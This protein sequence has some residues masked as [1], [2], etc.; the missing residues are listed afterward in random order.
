MHKKL[1]LAILAN[2]FDPIFGENAGGVVHALQVFA[3][4]EGVEI[5]FYGPSIARDA[6]LQSVPD[7][8]FV[9]SPSLS[10]RSEKFNQLSRAVLSL[11][12]RAELRSYD[13]L[14]ATSHFIADVLPLVLSRPSRSI[15]MLWHVIPPPGRRPGSVIANTIA[16]L[17]E[18]FSI[19]LIRRFIRTIIVGSAE[20]V[21]SLRLQGARRRIYI[22]TN[23]VDHLDALEVSAQ[24]TARDIG[25]LYIGRLHPSKGIG[26]LL[27]AWSLLS[28]SAR[29]QGLYL[30]GASATDYLTE[31]VERAQ[32]L[33]I[34]DC[35][36]FCGRVEEQEKWRLL[37]RARTFVFASTEEGWGIAIAEAMAA[38]VPCVTYDL[39][40]FQELF[41]TGRL[42]VAPG[43][44]D[45][46][47][48]A[49]EL[50]LDDNGLRQRLSDE[51]RS[52]GETF[53]WDRAA[54]IEFD[55]IA[56]TAAGD[57]A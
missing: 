6:F 40:V 18:R 28:D 12:I 3:R 46:L 24:P 30:A 57:H 22:T 55:A 50:V 7:S 8:H 54:R 26:D 19:F 53:S 20:L 10:T 56:I 52:L 27:E 45:A 1:R 37:A 41:A 48:R 13:A 39:P 16:Y 21:R 23:G 29:R 51:A 11:R 17:S 31:L 44:V 35:V 25:G 32:Q 4:W 34:S 2:T 9:P 43:N 42:G 38:G 5:T 33:G 15:A 47:G 49:I 36:H 14:F